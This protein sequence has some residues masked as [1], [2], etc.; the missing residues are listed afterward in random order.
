MNENV[1]NHYNFFISSSQRSSGSPSN[2]T[3]RLPFIITLNN[4]ISSNFQCYID[5]AQI[6]LAFNQFNPRSE[7]VQTTWT[8]SR[9]GNTYNGSFNIDSGNYSI[10]SLATHWITKLRQNIALISTFTP[11][12]TFTYS[13]DTNKL[14]FIYTDT[15]ASTIT[16]HNSPY[17]RLNQAL[18]FGAEWIM[19]SGEDYTQSTQDCNVGVSRALYI[20]SLSLRQDTNWSAIDGPLNINNIITYIPLT[21]GRNLYQQ[22]NPSY[23]IRTNLTND[24]IDEIQFTLRDE[25]IDEVDGLYSDWSFHLVIEEVRT[26]SLNELFYRNMTLGLGQLNQEKQ[27]ELQAVEQYKMEQQDEIDLLRDTQ[28]Q[29]VRKLVKRLKN[30]LFSKDNSKKENDVKKQKD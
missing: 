27:R 5:R 19:D 17:S 9:A 12:I 22:H 8:L 7:N 4:I 13:E 3:I 18:G 23:I 14:R 10:I 26:I 15:Q 1:L 21:H 11:T 6:P 16:I 2:F 30:K 20:T 24:V 25:L 29:G 28:V